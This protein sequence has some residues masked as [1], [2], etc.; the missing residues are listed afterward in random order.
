MESFHI[1]LSG[2][3][4]KECGTFLVLLAEQDEAWVQGKQ[5]V[6]LQSLK[7]LAATHLTGPLS[8]AIALLKRKT[9]K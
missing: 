8:S 6:I 9:S 3:S 7:K 1:F 4:S 2:L 5:D